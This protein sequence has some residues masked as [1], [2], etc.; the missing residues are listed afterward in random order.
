MKQKSF[1]D[2][3]YIMENDTEFCQANTGAF[4]A[5]D[6][7]VIQEKMDGA[8]A[9][10]AYD[11]ETNRLSAFARKRE[12]SYDNTLNGF[13]NWVQTLDVDLFSKYPDYVFFG[14][15]LTP[16]IIRYDDGAYKKFYFY[17]VYDRQNKIYLLQ[18]RVKQ[19]ADEFGFIYVNTLYDGEFISWEH[20]RSF[21][22]QSKTALDIGEG[23]VVKN[24]SELERQSSRY[25]F[26]LKIV[27]DNFSEIKKENHKRKINDPERNI[28]NDR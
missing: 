7:I 3:L 15:W 5:G 20:C 28:K 21:V 25:P 24:Q 22:G 11:T 6:H 4:K 26:A 12:L 1:M 23:I 14:E 8:N 27:V 13:W 17:D 2:I 19:L 18:N 10:I 9:S 16:H